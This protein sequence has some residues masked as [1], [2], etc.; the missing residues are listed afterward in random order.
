MP[1]RASFRI[2]RIAGRVCALSPI[3]TAMDRAAAKY[4]AVCQK[5]AEG[6]KLGGRPKTKRLDSEPQG[7]KNNLKVTQGTSR[8]H[9]KP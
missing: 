2:V 9:I 1:R 6:G 5:R 4:D 7:I 3:F 8:G